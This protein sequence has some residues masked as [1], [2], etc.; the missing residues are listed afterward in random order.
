MKSIAHTHK[1]EWPW[2]RYLTT[3]MKFLNSKYNRASLASY[4]RLCL[5]SLT[6]QSGGL[7]VSV[8]H[9]P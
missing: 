1:P 5:L 3:F 8:R 4:V 6:E 2:L 9:L 7:S